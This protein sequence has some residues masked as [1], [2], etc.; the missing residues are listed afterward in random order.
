MSIRFDRTDWAFDRLVQWVGSVEPQ[1]EQAASQLRRL[2]F[3]RF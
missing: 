1:P 2:R 3:L